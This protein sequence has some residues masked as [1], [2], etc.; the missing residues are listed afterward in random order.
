MFGN[1]AKIGQAS[2]VSPI[3]QNFQ[4]SRVLLIPNCTSNIVYYFTALHSCS[5]KFR[6]G[7]KCWSAW[8]KLS[9]LEQFGS[10]AG[11]G[12]VMGGPISDLRTTGVTEQE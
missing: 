7:N 2:G 5:A 11:D 8:S 4:T 9:S 1:F 10:D 3:W 12:W 6:Y